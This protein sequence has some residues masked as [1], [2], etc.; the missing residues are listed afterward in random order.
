MNDSDNL[1]QRA[2]GKPSPTPEDDN[3]ANETP[4]DASPQSGVPDDDIPQDD[5]VPESEDFDNS[6]PGRQYQIKD[7]TKYFQYQKQSNWCWIASTVSIWYYYFWVKNSQ[8]KDMT[9]NQAGLY[10]ECTG[11]SVYNAKENSLAPFTPGNQ[12]GNPE[13]AL[14]KR[15]MFTADFPNA[16][17]NLQSAREV[18]KSEISGDRPVIVGLHDLDNGFKHVVVFY[19]YRVGSD[20]WCV[21][22]SL[23]SK[24]P[25]A[26]G[27]SRWLTS[28]VISNKLVSNMWLTQGPGR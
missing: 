7:Y 14:R 15:A 23:G 10:E 9:I 27:K 18:L 5:D 6:N 3:S 24:V 8:Y 2:G 20:Q 22:D 12:T 16:Y 25:G 21:S 1:P 13:V 19:G 17:R 28:E 11:I 4:Q 26:L